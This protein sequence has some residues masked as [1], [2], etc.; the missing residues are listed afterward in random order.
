MHVS[1][2]SNSDSYIVAD[3]NSCAQCYPVSCCH[4][5]NHTF[6]HARDDSYSYTGSC[7]DSHPDSKPHC[8]TNTHPNACSDPNTYSDSHFCTD[9]DAH[10]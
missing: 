4:S 7:N 1:S 3:S 10:A 9:S 5:R 6:R 8:Y 2:K